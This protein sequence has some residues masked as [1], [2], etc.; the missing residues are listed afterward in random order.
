MVPILLPFLPSSPAAPR[1]NKQ[2]DTTGFSAAKLR[3]PLLLPCFFPSTPLGWEEELIKRYICFSSS[4]LLPPLFFCSVQFIPRREDQDGK[5]R[6]G[7]SRK[8]A[9]PPPSP[10]LRVSAISTGKK[11]ALSHTDIQTHKLP[12]RTI[13]LD[14][15]GETQWR[16]WRA[17]RFIAG[18]KSYEPSSPNWRRVGGRR[19][20]SLAPDSH[21]QAL[22]TVRSCSLV[23][24]SPAVTGTNDVHECPDER[25]LTIF[26]LTG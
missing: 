11:S 16:A 25:H 10:L 17:A 6:I 1:W 3:H 2:G 21:P 24:D 20:P 23:W 13:H 12:R 9:E 14:R 8:R 26:R 15:G 4:R 19:E 22:S 5:W 7:R 18:E